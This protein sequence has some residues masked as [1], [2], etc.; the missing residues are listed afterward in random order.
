[1]LESSQ[2]HVSYQKD[3]YTEHL[4]G[5]DFAV[6]EL[7]ITVGPVTAREKYYVTI[8]K[9]YALSFVVSF[10]NDKEESTVQKILDSIMFK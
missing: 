4:S 5:V 1:M 6:L 2:V 3:I 7:E 10:T 8:R 9:D